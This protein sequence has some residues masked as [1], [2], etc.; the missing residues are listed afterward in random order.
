M[1]ARVASSVSEDEEEEGQH[2]QI[3]CHKQQEPVEYI[4]QHGE[5]WGL[6][7]SL[8]VL[9]LCGC[10]VSV[11]IEAIVDQV[12]KEYKG[13][14]HDDRDEQ[15]GAVVNISP[16]VIRVCQSAHRRAPHLREAAEVLRGEVCTCVHRREEYDQHKSERFK[17]RLVFSA[18]WRACFRKESDSPDHEA[19]YNS[20]KEI[21]RGVP[22]PKMPSCRP[23]FICMVGNRGHDVLF[24]IW[25]HGLQFIR[26]CLAS[27]HLSL[28]PRLL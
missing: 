2:D 18:F 23:S 1:M 25:A 27:G 20:E 5:Q 6:A 19:Y 12:A 15:A 16:R 14:K 21:L 3:N 10:E 22:D 17:P 9:Q 26:H 11:R 4:A 13:V 7:E 8:M 28:G 24:F